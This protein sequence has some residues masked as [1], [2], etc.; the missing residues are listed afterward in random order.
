MNSFLYENCK[1]KLFNVTA[2]IKEKILRRKV[3]LLKA[4]L[5]INLILQLSQAC[6]NRRYGK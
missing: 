1:Y 3:S 2:K 5:Q 4:K 6:Y